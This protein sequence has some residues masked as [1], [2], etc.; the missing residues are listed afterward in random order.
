MFSVAFRKVTHG[1]LTDILHVV[2]IFTHFTDGEN[3]SPGG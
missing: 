1:I 2:G 3:E